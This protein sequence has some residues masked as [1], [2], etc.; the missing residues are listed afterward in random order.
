MSSCVGQLQELQLQL[1]VQEEDLATKNEVLV[2]Q[3]E[4]VTS[5]M[6]ANIHLTGKNNK[7][8]PLLSL[9]VNPCATELFVSF[10]HSLEAG[11]ANAISSFQ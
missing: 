3:Q 8:T 5:L 2:R 4:E 10:F 1:L 11:I 6:Q 7:V 9:L